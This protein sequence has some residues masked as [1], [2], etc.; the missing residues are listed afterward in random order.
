[1]IVSHAD[2]H[3]ISPVSQENAGVQPPGMPARTVNSGCT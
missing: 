3:F 2:G 1:M